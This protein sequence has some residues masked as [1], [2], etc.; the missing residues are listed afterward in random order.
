MTPTP[1]RLYALPMSRFL[2]APSSWLSRAALRQGISTDELLDFFGINATDGIDI[3][4]AIAH[5]D[6]AW[7]YKTC[8][9]PPTL[10]MPSIRIL[11]NLLIAKCEPKRFL[12]SNRQQP[13]FRFCPQCL[14]DQKTA[15]YPIHW[16]FAAFRFCPQHDC[17]L[18]ERCPKCDAQIFG[19]V[20]LMQAGPG[21]QGIAFLWKCSI[22]GADLRKAPVIRQ[23]E[24]FKLTGQLEHQL[25]RNGRAT[26]AALYVGDVY[27][28]TEP[29]YVYE[30]RKIQQLDLMGLI[31]NAKDWY[32]LDLLKKRV[33]DRIKRRAKERARDADR[34]ASGEIGPSSPLS[35]DP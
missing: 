32:P 9:L 2:E 3:D 19:S 11:R 25:M 15:Y 12:M 21:R 16:R 22:C 33:A 5:L 17:M 4:V 10:L 31:P 23:S 29:A 8:G 6:H 30:L 1:Q 34:M 26:L 35:E 28:R 14:E 18:E 27:L 13:V 24:V 20:N 7:L